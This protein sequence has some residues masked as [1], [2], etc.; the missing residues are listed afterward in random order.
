MSRVISLHSWVP[1]GSRREAPTAVGILM[2]SRRSVRAIGRRA[3]PKQL[4]QAVNYARRLFE[5]RLEVQEE[6]L[7]VSVYERGLDLSRRV[8]ETV[9][10]SRIRGGVGGQ[11]RECGVVRASVGGLLKEWI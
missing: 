2:V 10:W 1:E 3:G 4:R 7:A 8:V 6:F 5:G 9:E 11:L